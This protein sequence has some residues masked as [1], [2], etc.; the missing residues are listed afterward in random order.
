MRV[1]Q[2][3][4][5]DAEAQEQFKETGFSACLGKPFSMDG[6]KQALLAAIE[7]G[8]SGRWFSIA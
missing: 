4:H 8:A 7:G 2:T 1:S 5:V 6:L 3:G